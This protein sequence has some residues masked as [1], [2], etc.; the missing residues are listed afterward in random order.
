MS[1]MSLTCW[2]LLLAGAVT[3]NAIGGDRPNIVF[4]LADDMGVGDVSA[5]NPE[6]KVN[7]PALDAMIKEGMHFTDAHTSSAVCTPTRYGLMTGRYSWRTRLKEKVLGGYSPCII[8]AERETVASLLK[9]QGYQTAMIGKWHLGISWLKKDGTVETDLKPSG[10]VIEQEID[11]KAPIQLGPTHVGFD[12]FFGTAA[13]WD[14]PP[15]AFIENEYIQYE[16]LVK[17]SGCD[18]PLP[19]EVVAA[20]E[21]G[22]SK[23]ELKKLQSGYPKAAWHKGLAE[24]SMKPTDA[25]SEFTRRTVE[26][27]QNVNTDTPFFIY[28]PLTAPHTPVTPGAQFVGTSQAGI[29]GDFVHEV[30]W[31]VGQVID[32]LKAKGVFENT[33]L[34]FSTDNGYSRKAFPDARKEAYGHNPS[35]IYNGTKGRLLEGGHRVPFLVTWPGTVAAGTRSDVMICLTDFFA[36]CADITG[37]SF[38]DNAGEDSESFLSA[39]KGDPSSI[40]NTLVMRDFSG[41]LAVREGDWKLCFSR[42]GNHK[43]FDL[44]TDLGEQKSVMSSNPEKVESLKALLSKIVHEGRSTSGTPQK[45]DG[46][47]W[48]KQLCWEEPK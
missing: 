24:K 29:Y 14:M 34:I 12:Y 40:R 18:Y 11:F 36:T 42:T 9:K 26:Y 37:A 15:Y 22:M 41:Y 38:A 35:Y 32:A 48:W 1:K 43:M 46:P 19:A 25:M 6:A 3:L 20:K 30:D 2:G 47:E 33:L 7:T 8:P 31:T 44:A 21:S 27:I 28:M 4:I 39:L 16:E 23:A 17:S 5:L 10:E 13:S 45:N